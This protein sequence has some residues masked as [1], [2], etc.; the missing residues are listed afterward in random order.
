M[1]GYHELWQIVFEQGEPVFSRVDS[2]GSGRT[3]VLAGQTRFTTESRD[4]AKG[5]MAGHYKRGGQV[6]GRFKMVRMGDRDSGPD[7]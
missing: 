2:M 4:P 3:D 1:V 5:E 6:E 7:S